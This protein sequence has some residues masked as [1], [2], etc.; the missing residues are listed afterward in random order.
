MTR[1]ENDYQHLPQPVRV[2]DT[3]STKEAAPVA[4]PEAGR[5]TERDF[6]LRYAG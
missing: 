4:D 6:M 1:P 2:E 5:D 3:I